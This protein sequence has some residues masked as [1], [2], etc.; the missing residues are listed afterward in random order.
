MFDNTSERH[1]IN[2]KNAQNQR[3]LYVAC[4]H[5]H[6]DIVKFLLENGADPYLK[7]NVDKNEQ[8]TLLEVS[9]RWSHISILEYLL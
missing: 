4:K 7:S 6:L 1:M 2:I 3:P 8:E 9:A 5:G